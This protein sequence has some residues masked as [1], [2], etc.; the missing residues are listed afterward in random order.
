[1]KI[2]KYICLKLSIEYTTDIVLLHILFWNL[3]QKYVYDAKSL[4]VDASHYLN[5][6]HYSLY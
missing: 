2:H 6:L 5:T 4:G 3:C 1:M